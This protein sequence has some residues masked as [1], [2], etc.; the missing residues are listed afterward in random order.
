MMAAAHCS[1]AVNVKYRSPN[2]KKLQQTDNAAAC[3][4]FVNYTAFIRPAADNKNEE[5][6]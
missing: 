6:D 3:L 1:Q 2:G 4:C 5:G